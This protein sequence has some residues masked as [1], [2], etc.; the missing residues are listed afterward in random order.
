MHPTHCPIH[1]PTHR[2]NHR[3]N[4]H[5]N[6]RPNHRPLVAPRPLKRHLSS[7]LPARVAFTKPKITGTL[8]PMRRR[9]RFRREDRFLILLTIITTTTTTTTATKTT[10]AVT[11]VAATRR[12]TVTITAH[13]RQDGPRTGTVR[14]SAMGQPTLLQLAY[15]PLSCST[16]TV[17]AV[18]AQLLDT[19]LTIV[20]VWTQ[21]G[22]GS[23][24]LRLTAKETCL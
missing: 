12:T 21:A 14:A 16:T 11:L 3:S 15:R 19:A 22:A 2:L 13:S 24:I 4:Y 8:I 17:P 20:V 23:T 18:R 10:P 1:H 7:F 9:N 6:L 5:S